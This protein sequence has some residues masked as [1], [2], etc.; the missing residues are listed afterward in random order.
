MK[1]NKNQKAKLKEL[2]ASGY[3]TDKINKLA[4]QFEQPFSVSRQQVD[5]YRK[6]HSP[7]IVKI[8]E[9]KK[10]SPLKEGLAIKENR[11]SLLQQLADA[12]KK[13][14]IDDKKT[15]VVERVVT[16]GNQPVEIEGFN[17]QEMNQMR[18][19]LDDIAKETGGR[20]IN[21]NL[22]VR[23]KG[24]ITVTFINDREKNK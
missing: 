19:V 6:K 22:N 10:S 14:L 12:M 5:F 23:E 3:E 2:V 4:A 9:E 11:I 8:L 20:T 7:E 18:G 24:E 17:H 13:D 1:L 16:V 21:A 15:W